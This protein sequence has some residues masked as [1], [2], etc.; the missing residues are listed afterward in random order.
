MISSCLRANRLQRLHLRRQRLHQLGIAFESF[1]CDYLGVWLLSTK[2]KANLTNL[3]SLKLTVRKCIDAKQCYLCQYY[4]K[5]Q[6]IFN[7][8]EME[9]RKRCYHLVTDRHRTQF[10]EN[11]NIALSLS[12]ANDCHINVPWNITS[13]LHVNTVES[14]PTEYKTEC[15]EA[16]KLIIDD[17][18]YLYI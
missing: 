11:L 3:Y 12:I 14:H 6:F 15:Y 5:V 13:L 18:I 8:F 1:D 4:A 2:S 9:Y 17:N 7:E 10:V 16:A